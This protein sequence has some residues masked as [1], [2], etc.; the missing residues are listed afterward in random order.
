MV[1]LMIK[2]ILMKRLK[3]W[4]TTL[5]GAMVLVHNY[6]YFHT[7]EITIGTYYSWFVGVTTLLGFTLVLT[8]D[9][10]VDKIVGAVI[11][12]FK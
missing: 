8:G 6:W 4:K 10:W 5:I 2:Q 7:H 9:K 1:S 12:K 3:A 11:D